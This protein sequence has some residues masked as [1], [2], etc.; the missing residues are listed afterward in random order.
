MNKA[1]PSRH[2][3]H[4]IDSCSRDLMIENRPLASTEIAGPLGKSALQIS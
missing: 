4:L 3:T 1:L 2:L